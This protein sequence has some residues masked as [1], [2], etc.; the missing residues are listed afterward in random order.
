[1]IN[2]QRIK[3]DQNNT[4]RRREENENV[5]ACLVQFY[6]SGN[7][8]KN[9]QWKNDV[10][11][12]THYPVPCHFFSNDQKR[13]NYQREH[14]QRSKKSM[15]MNKVVI[16]STE[17][18]KLNNIGFEKSRNNQWDHDHKK[19]TGLER[20]KYIYHVFCGDE[21]TATGKFDIR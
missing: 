20:G 14:P 5:L 21:E 15:H 11:S 16:V 7:K 6:H 4:I 3:K 17:V 10:R 1:M 9:Q 19:I 18:G 8:G 2:G 13:L 12:F